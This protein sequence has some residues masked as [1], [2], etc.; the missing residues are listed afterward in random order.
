MIAAHH[1]TLASPDDFHGWRD[2]FNRRKPEAVDHAELTE[3]IPAI[4]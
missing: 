2:E 1:V 4:K 3:A